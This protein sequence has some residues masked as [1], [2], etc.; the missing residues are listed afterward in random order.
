MS[1]EKHLAIVVRYNKH[2]II[3]D[4]FL[5]LILVNDA[6]VQNLYNVITHFFSENNIPYK[7]NLVGFA[8]DLYVM[9]CICHSLALCASYVCEKLPDDAEKL[10]RSVLYASQF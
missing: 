1:S 10:V 5:G 4:H 7:E 3:K 8:A 9:K 6:S 2:F